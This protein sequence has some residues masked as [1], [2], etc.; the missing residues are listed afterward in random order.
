VQRTLPR[1]RRVAV[2]TFNGR[3]LSAAH[4]AAVGAD[5]ATPVVGL[6]DGGRFRAALLGDASVD[7]YEHR[8]AEAIESARRLLATHDRIGAIVLECTNLVPHAR[9]IRDATGLPVYDVM[10]LVAWFY[11]GL[12]QVHWPRP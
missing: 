5:P 9:A 8:E 6:P 10:T 4:L 1:G 2:L 11:A 7:G 12:E 3:S